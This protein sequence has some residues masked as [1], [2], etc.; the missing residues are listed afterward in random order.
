MP[1]MYCG[2]M[3]EIHISQLI[4]TN[5]QL[6]KNSISNLLFYIHAINASLCHFFT[7]HFSG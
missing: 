2:V 6:P 7:N 1:F 5:K 4:S 3:S